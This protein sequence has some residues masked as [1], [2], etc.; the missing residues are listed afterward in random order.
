MGVI[1]WQLMCNGLNNMMDN[2]IILYGASK[3]GEDMIKFLKHLNLE[4]KVIAII[5]SDER[6][7]EK[8]WMHYKI[9]GPELLYTLSPDALIVITSVYLQEISEY[10]VTD[11]YCSQN[12]SSI[13]AFKAALHYDVYGDS[14]L[15]IENNKIK[16]YKEEY[17]IWKKNYVSLKFSEQRNYFLNVIRCIIEYPDCILLHGTLKT[18]NI[19]LKSSFNSSRRNVAFTMHLAYYNEKTFGLIKNVI[20]YFKEHKIK[21]ITGVREPIERIISQKWQRIGCYYQNKDKCY[22]VLIDENYDNYI[23]D[24]ISYENS[25]ERSF[26]CENVFYTDIADWFYE[27][28]E[29][30][31][32]IN[33]F[34]HKFDKNK[35]YTIINKDNI[36]L[37]IYRL[38]KLS[39]LEQEISEFS[40]DNS[41]KLKK[42][43]VAS[44]KAYSLAYNEYK[45]QV[46]IEERFFNSLVNSKGMTHF[47][48][49]KECEKYKKNWEE[50]IIKM[51]QDHINH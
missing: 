16:K 39:G 45:K 7:W 49:E 48:T 3:T 40:E 27:H 9:S 22:P 28:I 47:Y 10:L 25:H 18:G 51:E 21:I 46:K 20:S 5:D 38:D 31:F 32:G 1:D 37:F 36:S 4:G 33:V 43:N 11:L 2:G 29:K 26:D 19:S 12:I 6:K 35:G 44:E 24:L 30:V 41:F 42:E 14:A 17:E 13:L 34:E 8:K 15:Y 23:T 50:K